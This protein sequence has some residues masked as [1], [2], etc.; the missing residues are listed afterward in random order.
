[1]VTIF[2]PVKVGDSR[3]ELLTPALS[4]QCSKPTELIT[5]PASIRIILRNCRKSKKF[6][7]SFYS[8]AFSYKKSSAF[9]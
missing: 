1:M 7:G 4:R 2:A 9:R 8:K 5:H 6:F 3:L